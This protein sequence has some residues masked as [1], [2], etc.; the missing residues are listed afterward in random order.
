MKIV[1]YQ[2][3]SY[4]AIISVV[5]IGHFYYQTF[6][7]GEK[8]GALAAAAGE[9][10]P[11]KKVASSP[12]KE[13][14]FQS[15]RN[16][17]QHLRAKKIQSFFVEFLDLDQER[18]APDQFDEDGMRTNSC[19]I[20]LVFQHKQD[21]DTDHALA[22]TV[23]IVIELQHD[24]GWGAK[25]SDGDLLVK[26]VSYDG[27]HRYTVKAREL[28][29]RQRGRNR[30]SRVKDFLQVLDDHTLLPCGFNTEKTTITGCRDFM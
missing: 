26:T 13:Y 19:M 4:C 8:G 11:A 30:G 3:Q 20:R 5:D 28:P 16:I 17:P 12:G 23:G 6:E 18:L 10:P 24:G 29:I 25:C 22:G 21:H 27:P 9:E 2:L 1:K 14:T 7:M 15:I